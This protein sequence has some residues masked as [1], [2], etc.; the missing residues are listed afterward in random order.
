MR[1]CRM[2]YCSFHLGWSISVS[3]CWSKFVC[4]CHFSQW[5]VYSVCALYMSRGLG[6][7]SAAGPLVHREHCNKRLGSKLI[8][9]KKQT[10]ATI[11]TPSSFFSY[12]LLL[13][14]TTAAT[15][16]SHSSHLICPSS[17]HR[18]RPADCHANGAPGLGALIRRASHFTGLCFLNSD[19]LSW[20]DWEKGLRVV[21]WMGP[22]TVAP[23]GK[24]CRGFGWS[25]LN[26]AKSGR[27][28]EESYS[29]A[30]TRF[31]VLTES[32]VFSLSLLCEVFARMDFLSL[33]HCFLYPSRRCQSV[34]VTWRHIWF[35]LF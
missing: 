28:V 14:Q 5:I 8:L 16:L 21:V 29:L 23:W 13:L 26:E 25:R 33:A 11:A 3:C 19:E 32:D 35:V 34:F 31:N 18:P 9:S 24:W 7:V 12:S 17:A 30:G 1:S 27:R 6:L 10:V 20:R 2:M 15:H 22:L 4:V